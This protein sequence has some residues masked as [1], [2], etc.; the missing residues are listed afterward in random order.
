MVWL[1]WLV[2]GWLDE[3]GE[4]VEKV[5]RATDDQGWKAEGVGVVIEIVVDEVDVVGRIP[6]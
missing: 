6:V 2:W 5:D 3:L 4:L 1:L